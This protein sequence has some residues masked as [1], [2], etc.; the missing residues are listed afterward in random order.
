MT[1]AD[2]TSLADFINRS[3][4]PVPAHVLDMAGYPSVQLSIPN[5]LTDST[6]PYEIRRTANDEHLGKALQWCAQ[7]TPNQYVTD[8][9]FFWF[10]TDEQAVMFKMVWG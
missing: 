10:D 1:V 2:R 8:Y 3:S 4:S 5:I 6:Q 7:N 9:D